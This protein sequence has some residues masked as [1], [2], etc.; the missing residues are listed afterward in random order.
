ME[1]YF[2]DDSIFSLFKNFFEISDKKVLNIKKYLC[3]F[4]R[5]FGIENLEYKNTLL[6]ISENEGCFEVIIKNSKD[7]YLL[8]I[9]RNRKLHWIKKIRNVDIDNILSKCESVKF[10]YLF[11]DREIKIEELKQY[12]L[13]DCF[14]ENYRTVHKITQ[15]SYVTYLPLPYY[16]DENLHACIIL[17]SI[18]GRDLTFSY[19]DVENNILYFGERYNYDYPELFAIRKS[20]NSHQYIDTYEYTDQY[21]FDIVYSDG[22]KVLDLTFSGWCELFLP[23][24]FTKLL[25]KIKDPMIKNLNVLKSNANLLEDTNINFL[26]SEYKKFDW[27]E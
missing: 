14:D 2:I 16:N 6:S 7:E 3:N 13:S 25:N 5:Y 8:K 10:P 17:S 26:N 15:F 19:I 27:F 12:D 23:D 22:L 1:E 9:S 11:Q 4:L 21:E 18:F 24:N 20:S